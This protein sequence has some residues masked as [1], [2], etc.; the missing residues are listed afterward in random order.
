MLITDFAGAIEVDLSTTSNR[1]WW[2]RAAT[3]GAMLFSPVL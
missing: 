1:P 2:F 3:R